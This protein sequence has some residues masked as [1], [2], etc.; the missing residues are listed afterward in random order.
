MDYRPFQDRTPDAQYRGLLQH[1][2]DSGEEVV[3]RQGVPALRIIGHLMRFRLDNGFPIVTERDLVSAS[4]DRP[5]PFQQALGEIC[6]FLN[7]AQTQQELEAFG[8]YWWA[9][10][11]TPSECAKFGLAP[12]DLGPA[13]YGAAFRRFP[14]AAG[15]TFDQV[16][17]LIEQIKT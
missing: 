12:G 5:S 2:L 3:T 15:E 9:D 13:S 11:V 17:N 1:I 7:G 4:N 6:A 16:T 8:C 14:T 10:W